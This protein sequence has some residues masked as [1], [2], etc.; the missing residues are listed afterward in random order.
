MP[1]AKRSDGSTSSTSDAQNR[2]TC[3]LPA[4]TGKDLDTIARVMSKAAEAVAG[5]TVEFTRPDVVKS[6][7]ARE[8]KRQATE[9][10]AAAKAAAEGDDTSDA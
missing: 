4:Q 7:V 8:L 10:E 9:A 2:F 3:Q 5:I 6:L 1:A